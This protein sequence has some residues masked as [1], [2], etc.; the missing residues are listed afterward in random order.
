MAASQ[1][2][3]ACDT[4]RASKVRCDKTRPRCIRCLRMG[5][6][7]NYAETRASHRAHA[8]HQNKPAVPGQ[9][10]FPRR[11]KPD[12]SI[13]QFQP[14]R[15]PMRRNRVPKACLRCRQSKVKCD[16]QEPCGRC[17]K[18]DRELECS[19]PT[20]SMLTDKNPDATRQVI[21]L[22]KQ[23]FHSGH[24]WS[25][26][27]ENIESLLKH[28]RWPGNHHEQHMEQENLYS[29]MGNFFGSMSPLHNATRRA[30]LSHIP[31]RDVADSFVEHYL[32]IIEPSHQILH[33]PTFLSEAERFWDKPSALS[34]GWLAQFLAILALGCHLVNV[35]SG[36]SDMNDSGIL[37]SQ[38]LDAAQA[39][40]QRTGFMIHPDLASIRALCLFVIFRQTKGVVCI[41]SAALWPA[42]GLIVRLAVMMGLHSTAPLHNSHGRRSPID[43]DI[44]NTLWASVILLDL[45]QS[46]AA[47]MPVMSPSRDLLSEPLFSIDHALL[48][49]ADRPEGL[50]F[51]QLIY[52]T[53]PHIFKILELATSAQVTLAYSLVATYDRQIRALLKD[54]QKP[55]L[56]VHKSDIDTFDT[57]R[58]QWTMIDV[59]FRRV[60][61]ALHS[62]L[63]QE[64]QASTRY[65]VSYWSSLECS[66]ALLS[67]QREL[68]DTVS[69]SS[70]SGS[71]TAVTAAF[72]YARLFQQE[73]FLAAVTVCFH[74]V[75]T[76][77]PFVSSADNSPKCQRQARHTILDLLHS[78][79]E[80]WGNEKETSICHSRSFEMIGTL[81]AIVEDD[82]QPE[83]GRIPPPCPGIEPSLPTCQGD[84]EHEYCGEIFQLQTWNNLPSMFTDE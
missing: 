15:G 6:C 23:T 8:S 66:L 31:P 41:E 49:V 71:T 33:V 30:L 39:C 54:Y 53:L 69:A 58:F 51:P 42:T 32:K 18:A 7:C 65:P 28:H 20:G 83:E 10:P 44:R 74:L 78:C 75:Q 57:K 43:A 60:L 11:N 62:R 40:L 61:L 46:L 81:L 35:S 73:F 64:P 3:Y 27:V 17:L 77:A 37:P 4:C 38:L 12:N 47:G 25:I 45:R 9:S 70:S 13:S 14:A 68:W 1:S 52:D 84:G 5:N 22:Y 76:Q 2:P 24:H 82:A 55:F 56:S 29:S 36:R 34:D 50:L 48:G 16:R 26:L 67:Q 79:K 80:I 59:F 19:Y 72:F 21:P 63:Y